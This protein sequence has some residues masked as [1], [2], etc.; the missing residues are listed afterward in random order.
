MAEVPNAARLTIH[1]SVSQ[2]FDGV[3]QAFVDN[4]AQRGELGAAC[5][6]YH[7]GA[8]VVDLW[9][10]TRNKATGEAW[11]EDTMVIVHSTTKGLVGL[12][13]ALAHSRGLVDYEERVCTYWPE[14]AQHGKDRVTVRQLLSHQAGLMALDAPVDKSTVA[15]LDRLAVALAMQKPAWP[16]GTRQGY[17]SIIFGFYASELLRR[18]DP[19]HR[20]LGRFFQDEI[21]S[22]LQ[23]DFYIGL[24]KEIPIS[25]LAIYQNFNP[26]K[27]LF[28]FN[29]SMPAAFML[30]LFNPL[31][32][33]HRATFRNP[34]LGV[35]FDRECIYTREIEQPSHGG[36]GTARAIAHA[37]AVFSTGGHELG[38]RAETLKQ[39]MAPAIAPPSGF[40]DEFLKF[41]VPFSLGFQKPCRL[42]PYS[43][44]SAFGH[45]GSGGSFGWCD[46][47]TQTAYGY[48][49][50][51][52]GF[53][54]GNDPRDLAL[55]EA[56]HQAI[57]H[58]G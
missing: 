38:L 16:P 13:M 19:K 46:P 22:P 49:T 5:C 15:D 50:N 37:Y 6:M 14:F 56:F 55:R 1:G 18:A 44:P 53:Y 48:V 3:R 24:P 17:P 52:A 21:A 2:G 7:R 20:S 58:Q 30:A 32:L 45:P 25:R 27:L 23:L 31:S 42:F 8:K 43:G 10:G 12:A 51:R 29:P 33:V 39:L 26:A 54:Q 47:E 4:F 36:V 41:E 9:G 11:D 40:Y 28:N 34:G 57:S 35:P